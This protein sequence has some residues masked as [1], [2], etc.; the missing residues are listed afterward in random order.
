MTVQAGTFPAHQS[1]LA[2]Y[3]PIFIVASALEGLAWLLLS[4]GGTTLVVCL[5]TIATTWIW[6]GRRRDGVFVR[7]LGQIPCV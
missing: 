3:W 5:K 7:W 4:P 2:D 6:V 1:H